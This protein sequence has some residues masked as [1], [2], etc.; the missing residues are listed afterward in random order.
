MQNFLIS[1]KICTKAF[2]ELV[3]TKLLLEKSQGKAKPKLLYPAQMIHDTKFDNLTRKNYDSQSE[4]STI[5]EKVSITKEMKIAI[6]HLN[7]LSEQ[8]ILL[9][10]NKINNLNDLKSFRYIQY[11][12]FFCIYNPIIEKLI[13]HIVLNK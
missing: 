8:T 6:K 10:E 13:K 7:S 5:H 3:D 4:N 1:D 11:V 2:N 9:T 12:R